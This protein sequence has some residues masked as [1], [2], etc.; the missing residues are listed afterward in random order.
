MAKKTTPPGSALPTV[1]PQGGLEAG[2]VGDTTISTGS[3]IH[4]APDASGAVLEPNSDGKDASTDVGDGAPPATPT[5]KPPQP[6]YRVVLGPI[7]DGVTLYGDGD[8][9]HLTDEEAKALGPVVT[10]IKE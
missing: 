7:W 6:G 3:E 8:E 5:P 2:P 10:P 4:S 9:I 1:P